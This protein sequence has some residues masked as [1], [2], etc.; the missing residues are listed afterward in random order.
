MATTVQAVGLEPLQGYGIHIR[1]TL[2]Y[3]LRGIPFN[4]IPHKMEYPFD[5]GL[6]GLLAEMEH[7]FDIGLA[8]ISGQS[9]HPFDICL[10]GIL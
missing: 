7:P 9:Q 4:V 10:A 3:L 6:A 5:I 2:K 8:G 1:A